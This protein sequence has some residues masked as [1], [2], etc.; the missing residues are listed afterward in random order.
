M[1]GYYLVWMQAENW[2]VMQSIA[3]NFF[4]LELKPIAINK[5]AQIWGMQSMLT[6]FFL[7]QAVKYN[8]IT[9]CSRRPLTVSLSSA[10]LLSQNSR[11]VKERKIIFFPIKVTGKVMF[12]K[13][14]ATSPRTGTENSCAIRSKPN[15]FWRRFVMHVCARLHLV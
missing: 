5:N 14:N 13:L 1:D 15:I 9:S 12:L 3:L 6:A 7:F 10:Y 11:S 8:F 4:G 2:Q